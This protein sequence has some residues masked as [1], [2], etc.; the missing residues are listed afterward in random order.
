[1]E[2]NA[3]FEGIDSSDVYFRLDSNEAF[4][5]KKEFLEGVASVLRMQI[6]MEKFKRIS[7]ELNIQRIAAKKEIDELKHLVNE[8]L[9]ILPAISIYEKNE[10]VKEEKHEIKKHEKKVEEKKHR[11]L[12]D[13]LDDIQKRLESL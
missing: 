8:L 3:E 9:E 13:E 11:T 4:E 7:E 6:D 1:M 10:E 2:K 5:A 12:K